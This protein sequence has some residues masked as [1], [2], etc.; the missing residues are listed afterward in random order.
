MKAWLTPLLN[1]TPLAPIFIAFLDQVSRLPPEVQTAVFASFVPCFSVMWPLARHKT[2]VETLL[3]CFSVTL[4][5]VPLD[6]NQKL[7]QPRAG[8]YSTVANT[9]LSALTR[10]SNRKKV[11]PRCPS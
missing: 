4:K 9:Y 3:E 8:I 2:N 5:T 1:H 7:A 10:A 11:G 6:T